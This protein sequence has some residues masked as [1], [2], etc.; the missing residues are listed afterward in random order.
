MLALLPVWLALVGAFAEVVILYVKRR[1]QPLLAISGDFVWM[2]P[3]A[4]LTVVIAIVA[5]SALL[6]RMWR[7]AASAA[8]ALFVSAAAVA[9]NLLMLV[10]GLSHY[11]GALLAAGIATQVTRVVR[12]HP[13]AAVRLMRRSLIPVVSTFVIAGAFMWNSL[14]PAVVRPAPPADSR[15]GSPNL[16]LITLDTVRAANLSLYGYSRQTTPRIDQFARRGVVFE[17][18]SATASW[19]LPSHASMFT[20]RWPHELSVDH[21]TPL[22]GADPTLAEYLRD[23]GYATAGF[24][25]NLKFVGASTGLNRGFSHYEDYSRSLGEVASSSTLVRT[26]ANNF[27]LRRLIRNDQHLNRMWAADINARALDWISGQSG[28]PFFVFINYFDAH[29]PYLPPPPFDRQFGPG[30][31]E[32]KYSPLHQWLWNS[33]VGR[34]LL[35][36]AV[37]QEELDAYDGGL[38]YLDSEVGLLLDGLERQGVLDN[39][40]VVITSD[41]GEEF[42]EHGVYEHGYSL[43]KAGVH[44]PLI[45][46]APRRAPAGLRVATPVN[47][48]DLAA[49]A[50]DLVG[51]GANAPFRGWSLAGL[52]RQDDPGVPAGRGGPSPSFSE[53]SPSPRQPDWYPSTKGDM[54]ALVHQG[55]RYIRNG[56][57]R[58]ELYDFSADPW[59]QT[60]L[61]TVPERQPDLAAARAELERLLSASSARH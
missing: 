37:K 44:V 40:V 36:D 27:R 49:T 9:L 28:S 30:R 2:A 12:G 51:L 48:R 26:V 39:T 7:P 34:R 45:V 32:G 14:R 33:A 6:A 61:A 56:D 31:R 43:Y 18:A 8:I 3:L 57:G 25:A 53:I 11:A 42:G 16:I 47:L 54:K 19:T 58:E 55:L 10:P 21:A 17:E 23:H 35:D 1:Q 38:A 41:H 5:L 50:V 13:D 52:W 20:G 60:N 59:E 29:E 24:A 22:D 15:A 4:L 46:V